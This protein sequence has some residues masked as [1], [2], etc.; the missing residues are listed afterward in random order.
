M[1]TIENESR[2]QYTFMGLFSGAGGL[3]LGFEKAG[4]NHVSSMDILNCAVSTLKRNRPNWNVLEADIREYNPTEKNVDVLLAGFPCQ[5]FSLGGHR[6]VNDS[7]NNLYKEVIRITKTIS[8]RVVV[9]ENVLNLRT[10]I[11]PVTN[12]PFCNQIADEMEAIGYKTIFQTFKVSQYG[13]PQ[14]RRRFIFIAFR[15]DLFRFYRFPDPEKDTPIRPFL[16][17]LGQ[18]LTIEL[19]NHN[20]SWGFSSTVHKET[21]EPYTPGEI[22]IPVRFSRTASEGTPIRNFDQPFPAVDTATLWGW[23]VGNVQA[24]R[25][26]KNRL[27]KDAMFV[28]NRTSNAK[29]WRIQAS[30]LR[31]F[32]H[33]EYARLQTFPDDWVFCGDNHRD[34]HLQ[35]GNA[36]PVEFAKRIAKSV[37]T[38]LEMQDGI[39]HARENDCQMSLFD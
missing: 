12:K 32:T 20:P 36:V 25:V 15:E 16:F 39:I 22:A 31:Q 17:N 7:R 27:E 37:R 34:I 6:D 29:L 21:N 2:S 28:R 24:S 8:P 35:I 19:P 10:M 13:V 1:F 3:D 9:M 23:A 11:H 18:D 38:A 33:R 5:G 4:F 26:E 30:Q 14:T